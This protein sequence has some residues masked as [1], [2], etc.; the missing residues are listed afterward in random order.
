MALASSGS[1]W[2]PAAGFGF[3]E[4]VGAFRVCREDEVYLFLDIF[5]IVFIENIILP[6]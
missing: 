1:G 4:S 6:F 2:L 5:L 3:G